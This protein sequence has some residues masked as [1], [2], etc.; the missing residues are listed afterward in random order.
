[1]AF[2]R[3][4]DANALGAGRA[5]VFTDFNYANLEA[6][7]GPAGIGSATPGMVFAFQGNL[8]QVVQNRF[9][10]ALAV[11]DAVSLLIGDT[12]RTGNLT[13]NST[14]AI[15]E[16]DDTQ[17]SGL[18]G[19]ADWPGLIYTTAGALATTADETKRQ[20]LANTVVTNASTV[21][22]ARYERDLGP[23][24]GIATSTA[25]AYGTT[26]DATY[27]Y[28]V[29]CP[30][31]VTKADLDALTTSIVQGY[32]VSTAITDDYFGIIQISGVAR[33][34]VDGT[35]D[36]VAGDLLIPDS[37]AGVLSK[38]A[39]GAPD[40]NGVTRSNFVCA[41]ILNAYTNN[42]V[43]LRAVLIQPQMPPVIPFMA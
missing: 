8:Y 15:V 34:K 13:G 21:T 26:P 42:G 40:A 14:K 29:F 1:M 36:L 31:E 43:G 5:D 24:Y 38:W 12:S 3:V 32:V 27:D 20:I 19:S 28:E 41:R 4:A 23:T 16:T 35:T 30:W 6:A 2:N 37:A 9:G 10:G 11:G 39:V 33:A 7:P 25:N 18:A 22:V 17:D